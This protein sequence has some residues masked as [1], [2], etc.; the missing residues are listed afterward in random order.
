MG[1]G[2]KR[3]MFRSIATA[4]VRR[5]RV[6]SVTHNFS[7]HQISRFTGIRSFST[8]DGG[9]GSS[10]SGEIMKGVVKWFDPKKGFGFIIPNDGSDDV[11]VHHSAIYAQGFRS[12]ADGED[13]EF[14][15]EEANGRRSA[16]D[17]TGPDGA[18]VIGKP[19]R[20]RYESG[21]SGGGDGGY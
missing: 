7:S 1:K 21:M 15:V 18:Y 11:F 14:N 10:G 5:T 6:P 3:T 2:T 17:V 19:F 4:A 20:P 13:V 16:M 9:E 8:E 12:L